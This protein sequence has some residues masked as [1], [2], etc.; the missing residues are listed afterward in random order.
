MRRDKASKKPKVNTGVN[1]VKLQVNICGAAGAKQAKPP[2]K[3]S[4]MA[5]FRHQIRL[6]PF[7]HEREQLLN[8]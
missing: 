3:A 8:Q 5:I 1:N 2:E 4:K 6:Q 7:K